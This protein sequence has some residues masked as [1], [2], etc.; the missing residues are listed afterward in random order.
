MKTIE[1]QLDIYGKSTQIVIC[2]LCG[3]KL[4]ML[5][6]A[7]S[8]YPAKDYGSEDKGVTFYARY[9]RA[10][11]KHDCPVGRLSITGI[12]VDCVD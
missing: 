7:K 11:V 9:A 5:V 4:V 6:M 10:A 12:L 8:A 2:P 3:E 1:S